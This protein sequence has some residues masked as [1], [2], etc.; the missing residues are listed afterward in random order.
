MM[1]RIFSGR[2]DWSPADDGN[3]HIASSK[4][5][6]AVTQVGCIGFFKAAREKQSSIVDRLL[7]IIADSHSFREILM[8]V[9]HRLGCLAVFVLLAASIPA[10]A[11][12]IVGAQ[13]TQMLPMRDGA[14]LATD[15]YL[16]EGDGP[17]PTILS[18]TPYNKRGVQS[19]AKRFVKAGFAVVAQD[20]RGRFK[21]AGDYSPFQTDHHDGYDTV[22]WIAV[23]DW[24]DGKVGMSG[25]SAL[26]I[27]TN[28][29]ATQTPPH[30]VCGYVVVAPASARQHTVYN[31][32][33]YRKEMNDG[34]LT[35]MN[36]TEAIAQAIENPPS[37]EFWNWRE[38]T[39]FHRRINIPICNVG[40]WFDIFGQGTI[41]NFVGLQRKGAG[42]ASGNQKLIMGPTGH[43]P[44]GGRLKFPDANGQVFSA[45]HQLRWFSY[46][47]KGEAN[48]IADEPPVRYYMMGDTD[49]PD[50]PGN[51]W[52][53]A[54]SWP[55]PAQPTSFFLQDGHRLATSL[56]TSTGVISFRYD[57]ADPVPTIGGANLIAGGK[58]PE[59]QR[60]IDDR[61]DYLRF[62]T[63]VLTEPVEVAG[64]VTVDL[65]VA[66]DA[67]DTDFV[68]KLVDV[69]PDG[70]EALICDGI[71]RARYREGLD[72]EVMMQPDEVTRVRIDL[73]STA[74]V[75]N[76]GHRIALHVSSSNDP[77]YDPNPNTG[78]PLRSG[79][80]QR[81]AE[82]S[83]HFSNTHPSRLLLPVVRP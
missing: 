61:Q 22:E 79:D 10:V 11:L 78:A 74:I 81:V 19:T 40:G 14:A 34:W 41:D 35:M 32:G 43:G 45:D 20:C 60:Q 80:E 2:S 55:P 39:D 54:V 53:E 42:L 6:Q 65:H 82:N 83:V 67:P 23:Q 1:K 69:Y 68:A 72:R 44:L 59:D 3:G 76:K 31:G 71:I 25:G 51:E 62:Q 75:F 49:D 5:R 66:S 21:S 77:R 29:A 46:W 9:Y 8:P 48:G 56:P 58:G 15:V 37:S 26:G 18:R 52:R 63:D 73:W 28:L 27:T 30:L 24:S 50:A 36:A 57:P 7:L 13:E 47:L 38:I 64:R 17:W 70:Y 33:V 12:P 16:P 4:I